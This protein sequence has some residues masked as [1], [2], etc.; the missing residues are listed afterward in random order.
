MV[1][2]SSAI[3]AILQYE[4][5]R[6][7]FTALIARAELSLISAAS[8]LETHLVL[9]RRFGFAETQMLVDELTTA[10]SVNV[11]PVTLEIAMIGIE[12]LRKY[13]KGHHPAGL[14][15]GDLL[16]YATAKVAGLPLLFKGND[17]SLTDI[18]PAYFPG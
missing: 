12:A 2:D 17:F 4:S 14:N 7:S 6:E 15:F 8:L 18:P 5:E 13:G 9:S 10:L 3:V 16:S 11:V 1:I